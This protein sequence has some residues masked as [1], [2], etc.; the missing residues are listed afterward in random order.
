MSKLRA[1]VLFTALLAPAVVLTAPSRADDAKAEWVTVKGQVLM[2]KDK[3]PAPAVGTVPVAGSDKAH[4]ESKGPLAKTVLLV[5]PK[6]DGV[7][8]VVAFLR[9]NN[10]ERKLTFPKDK[11]KPSLVKVAPTNHVIDQP[12]CQF[13]PRVLAVRVGDTLEVKNS[14]PVVHNINYKGENPFNVNVPAGMSHKMPQPFEATNS[15]ILFECNVHP[16]MAGRIR[17]FDHPYYAM[18]D[19]DGKFEI[20]DVPAGKWKIV[21]WHELGIHDSTK[22]GIAGATIDVAGPTLDL[23]PIDLNLPSAK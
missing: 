5:N 13:E 16:W 21:Y 17:V 7:K 12:C 23:K 9:P 11:I 4:C 19:A 18:T 2:S 14:S 3:I 8:N 1:F 20:K 10:D 6:N 15:P 22:G